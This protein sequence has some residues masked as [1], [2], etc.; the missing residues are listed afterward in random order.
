MIQEGKRLDYG[1]GQ[2]STPHSFL[3]DDEDRPTRIPYSKPFANHNMIDPERASRA[4]RITQWCNQLGAEDESAAALAAEGIA[5]FAADCQTRGELNAH[6]LSNPGALLYLEGL[7]ST[8]GLATKFAVEAICH[9]SGSIG[10][11]FLLLNQ[12]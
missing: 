2:Y 10:A 11:H 6:L 12:V 3:L 9:L 4:L 1:L 5:R 8:P 7:V